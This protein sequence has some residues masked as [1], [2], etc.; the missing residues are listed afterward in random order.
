MAKGKKRRTKNSNVSPLEHHHRQGKSLIPPMMKLRSIQFSSWYNDR[1]PNI[2]WAALII[3][4][5]EREEGLELF[6]L[7]LGR[8][9]RL[10]KD[11]VESLDHSDL[12]SLPAEVFDELFEN[13]LRHPGAASAL[14]ALRAF[15]KLP[16]LHHWSRH[17]NEPEQIGPTLAHTIEETF[18]HQSQAATDCRW[19]R[20]MAMI[21]TDRMVFAQ[22][23]EER[24]RE[25]FEYPNRGDQRSVR[26]SIRA[27]E[28]GL[29]I[30]EGRE[31][32]WPTD[33]WQDCWQ[34]SD[35]ILIPK[36]RFKDAG[37]SKRGNDV[38]ELYAK[39]GE[40]AASQEAGTSVS[41]RFDTVF[42]LVMYALSL[43]API[44]KT[45]GHAR[46]EG[47]L[48][49][50]ALVE[51]YITLSYLLSE[52]S[53]ELWLKYRR[54]G[55]GQAKLAY[56]KLYDLEEQEQPEYV[57][58][59]ALER[60]ANEDIWQE[61]TEINLGNWAGKDLRA[62]AEQC[63]AKDVYDKYYVWPSSYMHS[64]WTAVR[65]VVFDQCF[66]PLH[67][68]HRIPAE[69]NFQL[70]SVGPDMV[71]LLNLHLDRLNQAYPGFKHR[72][73]SS[74]TRDDEAPDHTETDGEEVAE[75]DA[76]LEVGAE[77]ETEPEVEG[78]A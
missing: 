34:R 20:M 70:P 75:R 14:S 21:V 19:L 64:Q 67:R 29:G 66:N 72:M 8:A 69:P 53:E 63:G 52:D 33:F 55:T 6:R 71:K 13:V 49:L 43:S 9:Q 51:S 47:R 1:L 27:N 58:V 48:V 78:G 74:E 4:S 31:T 26:P 28:I 57:P 11:K 23:M 25:F 44:I 45:G 59:D 65:D 35:C 10:G 18:D 39:V 7:V 50:R 16:D 22:E 56:L 2:L 42:G 61:Y 73:Q 3:T 62:L 77:A 54:H 15:E 60:Y 68:F 37:L 41:A 5:V 40:Y 46:A 36:A 17:L 76:E 12:A 30:R 38:L 24:V 32:T